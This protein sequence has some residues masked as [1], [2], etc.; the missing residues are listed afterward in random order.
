MPLLTTG[1]GGFPA[2]SPAGSGWGDHGTWL[3]LSTTTITNDTVTSNNTSGY[4]SARGTQA[5]STGKN[6]FEVKLLTAPPADA[7]HIGI[8][9][10]SVATGSGMDTNS[11]ANGSSNYLNNG[12]ANGGGTGITGVNLGAGVTLANNDILAIAFDATNGFHYLAQ[13]NVWLLSGDPTSGA[14]GTGHVAA[15]SAGGSYYPWV[16]LW[17][18]VNGVLQLVTRA[19]DF[20][21][22]PPSGYSA[23][24]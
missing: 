9:D 15:Y 7:M 12:N 6:Y 23:W 22:T 2:A 3:D 1:A 5:R 20:T 14:T 10:N 17:A 4:A 19:S 8:L 21:Y 24:G 11:L 18:T 13:N 16:T